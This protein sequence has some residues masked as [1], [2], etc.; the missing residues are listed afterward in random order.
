MKDVVSYCGL[1]CKGCPILWATNEENEELKEKMKIEISRL[2]NELYKTEYCSED[3]TDCDGCLAENGRLF[4]GCVNCQIRNCA[5]EKKISNCA[6]CGEYICEKL[7]TFF[8]DNPESK[9][10]LDFIRS[11][12]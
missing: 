5:R 8:K 6:Y 3:I 10:R 9:S 12:L 4:P 2:C 7:E 1:I 11:V